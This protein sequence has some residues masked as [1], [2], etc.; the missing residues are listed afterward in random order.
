MNKITAIDPARHQQLKIDIS[1]TADLGDNRHL[2]DVVPSEFRSLC[3]YYPILVSKNATTGEYLF[4]SLFGFYLEENLYLQNETW[5]ATYIP[6]NMRRTP[7]S[8]EFKDAPNQQGKVP[9]LCIQEDH[10]RVNIAKGEQLFI[11][12]NA[13]D[14][15]KNM[16]DIVKRLLEGG[17][18]SKLL[19]SKMS[20]YGLIEP[21]NIT[22]TFCDGSEK[23][24]VGLYSI[25][26]NKLATLSDQ[27]VL[28]LHQNKLLEPI[29][30]MLASLSQLGSLVNRKNQQLKEK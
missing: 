28:D 1:H 9:V 10:P 23:S 24:L 7:F 12:G 18:Q 29:Y 2:I 4:V 14:Y 21:L 25:N 8:V 27:Q 20:D 17:Q 16:Q 15:L 3:A 5:D 19:A 30:A 6:L 13:S 22:I 26:E 11:E